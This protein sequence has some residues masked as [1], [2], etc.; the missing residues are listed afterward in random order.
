MQQRMTG[1]GAHIRSLD[2]IE[3]AIRECLSEIKAGSVTKWSDRINPPN[4]PVASR[5]CAPGFHFVQAFTNRDI[6][7]T[8][9]V[10]LCAIREY[11]RKGGGSRG[12]Y[13]VQDKNGKLPL[14]MLPEDFRFSL[15]DGKLLES[16]GEIALDIDSMEC[17]CE[18]NPVRP[19]PSEDNWF[20]TVW[21][22]YRQGNVIK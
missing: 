17:E 14:P 3:L 2:K 20:E 16:V 1:C 8:Q 4:D 19:I 9:Y 12:S 15:D 22:E 5:C 21:A 7:I 13:L 10:Y 6:L 11:I 18:W